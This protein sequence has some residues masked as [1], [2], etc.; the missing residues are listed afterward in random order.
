MREIDIL[1]PNIIVCCDAEDTQ[2]DY[3]A[4]RLESLEMDKDK[5]IKID[6]KYPLSPHF[7]C[8]L[9]FYPTLN[10]VVISSFHPTRIG[11]A[12]DWTI[13]EKVISPFK[14]L[15]NNYQIKL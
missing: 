7:N 1:N 2:F 15:L 12:G 8:H 13:Y 9:R 5:I 10:K 4:K 3:I 14:Q 6:Y 11:K